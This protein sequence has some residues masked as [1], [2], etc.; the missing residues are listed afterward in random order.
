MAKKS[1]RHGLNFLH[2][3]LC[4]PVH[5]S[6]SVLS[7]TKYNFGAIDTEFGNSYLISLVFCCGNYSRAESI[8]GNMVIVINFRVTVVAHCNI[9]PTIVKDGFKLE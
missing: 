9:K 1:C 5:K 6:F 4:L 3:S 2:K 8:W 7:G